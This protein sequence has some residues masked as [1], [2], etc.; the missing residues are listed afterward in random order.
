M[1]CQA[2]DLFGQAVRVEAFEKLDNAPMQHPPSLLKQTFVGHL[3]GEGVLEGVCGGWERPCLIEELGGL[4]VAEVC[5]VLPQRGLSRP[6][7][8]AGHPSR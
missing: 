4:E 6:G 1:V 3:L 8:A 2:L 7:G 5:G